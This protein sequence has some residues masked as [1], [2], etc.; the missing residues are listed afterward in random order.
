MKIYTGQ[1]SGERLQKVLELGMGIMVSSSPVATPQ[2]EVKQTYCALD[3]GAYSCYRKG[4][5][6]MKEVFL[7]QIADC[8]KKN[9]FLDFIVTPDI[10]AGGKTS[11][12]FSLKWAL[13]ELATA[14]R[15]ALVVHSGLKRSDICYLH[16]FT[17]I[18]IGD[19]E[20]RT[21]ETMKDWVSYAR[22]NGKLV[23]IGH[24]GKYE[25]L[26]LAHELGVDS[27]DS[28]S[29]VVNNSFHIVERYYDSINYK[30]ERQQLTLFPDYAA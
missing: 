13:N 25:D 20:N 6:F 23:H 7:K 10:I 26:M 27:V 19:A 22:D 29:W 21:M 2:K 4:Y 5:P 16:R 12:D 18:F 28:T 11:F 17:H 14:P 24:S 30:P 8:Y 3:N 9:I 1:C 15:L